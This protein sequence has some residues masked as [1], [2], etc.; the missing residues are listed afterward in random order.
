MKC[1]KYWA[2]VGTNCGICIRVCLF[3]KPRHWSHDVARWV[4][5]KGN[6]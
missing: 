5:E 3:N 4:I 1:H 6:R 2:E